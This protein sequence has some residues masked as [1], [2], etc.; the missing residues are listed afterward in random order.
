MLL[1]WACVP[2]FLV[3][4]RISTWHRSILSAERGL[5]LQLNS[6]VSA[7]DGAKRDLVQI[8]KAVQQL[9]DLF[10]IVAVGEFNS[11]KS[12]LL[13][14]LLGADSI[15]PEGAIPT[16]AEIFRIRHSEHRNDSPQD[17]KTVF[18]DKEWLRNCQLVDTPGTNAIIRGHREITEDLIPRAD[19][20]LFVTSVDRPISESEA[21]FLE[22]I[23]KWRKKVVFVLSKIDQLSGPEDLATVIQYLKKH[24]SEILG[25]E[26]VDVDFR[27]FP[28]SSK[29]AKEAHRAQI[30]DKERMLWERSGIKELENFVL[31]I[32]QNETAIILKLMTP[33]NIVQAMAAKYSDQILKQLDILKAD[34]ETLKNV[35]ETIEAFR[36]DMDRDV[37]FHLNGIDNVLLRLL[38]RCDQFLDE[39]I[40]LTKIFTHVFRLRNG[41][42]KEI[43]QREVLMDFSNELENHLHE[44]A[45][46]MVDKNNQLAIDVSSYVQKKSLKHSEMIVC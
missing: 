31:T 14:T 15:C 39:R 8:R 26:N 18:V 12:A 32:I 21:K 11:G 28:V 29:Q 27:I 38:N 1:R 6:A 42:M 33:I 40:T 43:F 36:K 16:T 34:L 25:K 4:R 17:D 41:D 24:A 44:L 20:V 37:S 3:H 22:T 30:S 7:L 2:G 5:L 19:L 23:L 9:E 45:N 46:W 10:L 13:N 35:D